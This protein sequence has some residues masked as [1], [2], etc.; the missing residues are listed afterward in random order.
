MD[1]THI[2]SGVASGGETSAEE[3]IAQRDWTTSKGKRISI[4][5]PFPKVHSIAPCCS[6]LS[7]T[8]SRIY[9]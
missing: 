3:N 6:Y 4:E 8:V 2:T 9:F 1:L 5:D 7:L